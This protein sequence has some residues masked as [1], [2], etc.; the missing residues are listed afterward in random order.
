[1]SRHVRHRKNAHRQDK[2]GRRCPSCGRLMKKGGAC[3]FEART[4]PIPER[5]RVK[6]AR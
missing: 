1:M 6:K 2:T 3:Q 4:P 5:F